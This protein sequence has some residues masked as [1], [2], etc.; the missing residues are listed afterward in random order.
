MVLTMQ[1]LGGDPQ[2][3][4]LLGVSAVGY[5]MGLSGRRRNSVPKTEI[6]SSRP[7]NQILKLLLILIAAIVWVAATLGSARWLPRLRPPG[8]PPRP[9]LWMEWVPAGVMVLWGLAS[10]GFIFSWRQR[11]WRSPLGVTLLGLA[12]SSVLALATVSAQV[13]PAIEYI[14]QT[15]RAGGPGSSDPYPFSIEPL[16]L[17]E[18][19]W[20]NI[21][22]VQIGVNTYW[23]DALVL[24]GIRPEIWTPSLYL[25]GLTLLLAFGAI[26]IRNGPPWRIWLIAI[27]VVSLVGSLGQF[28]SPIWATRILAE[29]SAWPTLRS[30]VRDLGPLDPIQSPPIRYD[31]YLRDGDGSIYW[32]LSMVLPG[33]RQF[34]FPAKL[35]TFTA[36]GLS[37]LAGMGWDRLRDGRTRRIVAL[38]AAL[39]VA[40]LAAMVFVWIAR[41]ALL[42][43]FQRP[44]IP[45]MFGPLDPGGAY[46]VLVQSLSQAILVSGLGLVAILLV[47]R[48]PA[49]AGALTLIVVTADLAAA[50]SRYVVT[51]PQAALESEPEVMRIIRESES[52]QP[53]A[54]PFRIHRMPAWHPPGWQTTASL[55]RVQD[56][57]AWERGTLQPKYGINLGIEYTHTF[58]VGQVYEYDWFF[59]GQPRAVR[60]SEGA[61]ALGIEIGKEIIYFPRRS[62][63]L[64]NTRYFILPSYPHG[65][66]DPYRAYA[67]FL[68]QTEP[69]YPEAGGTRGPS[70]SEALSNSRKM[71]SRYD[72]T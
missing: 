26:G 25:G 43:Q 35:F 11:G 38:L 58:G 45:S 67:S 24:P 68:F 23:R 49:R 32:W 28:T 18:L 54:G 3:S 39:L 55:D 51:V 46:R 66:R 4:Y 64:W 65:W 10:L 50:N 1:T 29:I 48:R 41:P 71:T 27:T 15:T 13:F 56:M 19:I 69:V 16:R 63:D 59:D 61:Q 21:L 17:T 62:F 12:L 52:K 30:L 70:R 8:Y 5:A 6:Q 2:S 36:L 60:T 7:R 22:G 37:T 33:F 44:L 20:P 31:G 42:E 53:S 47:R 40:S 57:V 9:L 14:Q 72:A 34:R